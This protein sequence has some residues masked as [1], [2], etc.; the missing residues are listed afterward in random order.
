MPQCLA[1]LMHDPVLSAVN[2]PHVAFNDEQNHP[3]GHVGVY[4]LLVFPSTALSGI[5]SF[6]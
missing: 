2:S 4:R 5:K 1:E 3:P 6:L